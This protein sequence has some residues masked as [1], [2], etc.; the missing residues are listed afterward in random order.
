MLLL[1]MGC[2]SQITK[3]FYHCI[4]IFFFPEFK[5]GYDII[6]VLCLGQ[7]GSLNGKP[8]DNT[9]FIGEEDGP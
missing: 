2:T 9:L 7:F 5:M 8:M 6:C 4:M 3:G 1:R